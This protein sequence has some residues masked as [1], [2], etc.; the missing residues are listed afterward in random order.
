MLARQ[1]VEAQRF[2]GYLFED[3]AA[4]YRRWCGE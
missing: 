2:W 3:A 1:A 4:V